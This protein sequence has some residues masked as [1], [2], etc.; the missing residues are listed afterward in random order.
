MLL[1]AGASRSMVL[2]LGRSHQWY[3]F[4]VTIAGAG[5]YLRRYA[6][7]VETGKAGVSDPAMA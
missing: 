3:D 4:G 5:R 2:H 6:G 7:R 1:G